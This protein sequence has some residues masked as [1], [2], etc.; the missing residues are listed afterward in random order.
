MRNIGDFIFHIKHAFVV[1]IEMLK[2]PM[3][4]EL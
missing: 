4:V 3:M 1:S 2:S